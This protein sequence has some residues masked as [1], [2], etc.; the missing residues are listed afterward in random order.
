[1]GPRAVLDGVRKIAPPP[2]FDFRTI[3]PIASRYTDCAIPA[4]FMN[5]LEIYDSEIVLQLH[6]SRIPKKIL[7]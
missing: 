2:E 3:Q 1:V 4:Y 7:S 5:I 6:S